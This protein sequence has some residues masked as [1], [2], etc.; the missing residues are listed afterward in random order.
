MM[1]FVAT[2]AKPAARS[3]GESCVF[4]PKKPGAETLAVCR[5]WLI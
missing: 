4:N 2:N 3:V 5:A 1:Q